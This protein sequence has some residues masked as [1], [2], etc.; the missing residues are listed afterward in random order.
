MK[1]YESNSF[2][3]FDK[4]K[5]FINV[6]IKSQTRNQGTKEISIP[7]FLQSNISSSLTV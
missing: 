5:L 4:H 2:V 3:N 6:T 1:Y 7:L